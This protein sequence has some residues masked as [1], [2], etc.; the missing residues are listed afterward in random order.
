MGMGD[1][2]QASCT[3]LCVGR[4]SWLKA[5]PKFEK[6]PW[7]GNQHRRSP[8]FG[9]RPHLGHVG[10]WGSHSGEGGYHGG[11]HPDI[12]HKLEERAERHPHRAAY[13]LLPT[14]QV[15][16]VLP[17]RSPAH[18]LTLA[19]FSMLVLSVCDAT[20][21]LPPFPRASSRR[22]PHP[23]HAPSCPSH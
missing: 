19:F 7:Q 18:S 5:V 2:E 22:Q 21:P 12:Y 11:K 3:P 6:L 9:P 15:P 10:S 8:F 1:F 23:S 13:T 4:P 17:L 16:G 20:H 14:C